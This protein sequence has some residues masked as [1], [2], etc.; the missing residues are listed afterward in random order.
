MSLLPNNQADAELSLDQIYTSAFEMRQKIKSLRVDYCR[1]ARKTEAAAASV[2]S[3]FNISESQ[4]RWFA[5]AFPKRSYFATAIDD[6]NDTECHTDQFE[7]KPEVDLRRKSISQVEPY[8]IYL[9]LRFS[10]NSRAHPPEDV[11]MYPWVLEGT[12]GPYFVYQKQELMNGVDCHVIEWG[13]RDKIWVDSRNPGVMI[14]RDR[15][16]EYEDE[17][18]MQ[19]S[20]DF[21]DHEDLG[22]GVALPKRLV[23]KEFGALRH[24]PKL[25][26]CIVSVDE[27]EVSQIKV[28]DDVTEEDFALP[29]PHHDC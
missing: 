14:R 20:I 16:F 6:S 12:G 17:K 28:N 13:N 3:D 24:G 5:L 7:Y 10:D 29:L 21:F 4:R 11:W 22:D 19:S 1:V 9:D 27:L 25:R 2:C 26:D 23:A 8:C 15:S 18:V